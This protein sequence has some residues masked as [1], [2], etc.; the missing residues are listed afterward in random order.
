MSVFFSPAGT[1]KYTLRV[2]EKGASNGP[3]ARGGGFATSRS[4][5][6]DADEGVDA[7]GDADA[8]VDADADEGGGG[9]VVV[10]G[11]EVEVAV[12]VVVEVAVA[13]EQPV[14]RSSVRSQR[15]VMPIHRAP[16]S[17]RD[18]GAWIS[19]PHGVRPRKNTWIRVCVSECPVR[20][21]GSGRTEYTRRDR[22]T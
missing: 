4:T 14:R 10:V 21:A 7:D 11:V 9:G 18:G 17:V 12:A 6:R 15:W 2:P 8:D 13:V 3:V 19:V 1:V 16:R 20:S 22:R 5:T